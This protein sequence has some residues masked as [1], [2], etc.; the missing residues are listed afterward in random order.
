MVL[1]SSPQLGQAPLP[2]EQAGQASIP[3]ALRERMYVEQHGPSRR[4]W[5]YFLTSREYT[6]LSNKLPF[7][8]RSSRAAYDRA[9]KAQTRYFRLAPYFVRL[10]AAAAQTSFQVQDGEL[11]L[12]TSP[13]TFLNLFS[14]TVQKELLN[15][16]RDQAADRLGRLILGKAMGRAFGTLLG[17]VLDIIGVVRGIQAENLQR[18]C[19]RPG[20]NEEC[21]RITLFL[22]MNIPAGIEARK[23]R[24]PLPVAK[25]RLIKR[26]QEY[27]A[28]R[29]EYFR[30]LEMDR[31]LDPNPKKRQGPEMRATPPR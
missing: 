10:E 5:G 17:P 16:I 22:L 2:V 4:N 7:L 19:G 27:R 26:W 29:D 14:D 28:A 24:E 30:Y 25:A 21:F 3:L 13:R 23:R 18:R 12:S 9:I 1:G 20:F 8:A 31:K 15:Y 6:I 11:V